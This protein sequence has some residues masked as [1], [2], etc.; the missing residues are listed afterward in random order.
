MPRVWPLGVAAENK[1]RFCMGLGNVILFSSQMSTQV[2]PLSTLQRALESREKME[3]LRWE[4][5]RSMKL[6]KGGVSVL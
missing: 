2:S 4:E 1:G 5:I 3:G 6:Q